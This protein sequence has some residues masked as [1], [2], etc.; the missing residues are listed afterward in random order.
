MPMQGWRKLRRAE[1][2]HGPIRGAVLRLYR[3]HGNLQAVADELGVSRVTLY[4][5]LGKEEIG[6]LKAQATMAAY[7]Q[8]VQEVRIGIEGGQR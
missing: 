4:R 7:D 1:Q 5:Y 6:M 2:R 8:A 3:E